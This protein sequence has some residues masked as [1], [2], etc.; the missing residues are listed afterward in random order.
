MTM[1]SYIG[2]P[3]SVLAMLFLIQLSANVFGKAAD[4]GQILGSLP[5]MWETRMEFLAPE[6]SL[7]Q[8]W[9]L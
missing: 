5:L 6:F 7:S 1:A 3:G 4:D 8:T 2:V 9:L